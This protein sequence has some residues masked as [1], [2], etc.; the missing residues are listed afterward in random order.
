[1]PLSFELFLL[2]QLLKYVQQDH[3]QCVGKAFVHLCKV[4]FWQE[5]L[6]S[7]SAI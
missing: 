2:L 7:D 6:R 1:M 4:C 3:M 5:W